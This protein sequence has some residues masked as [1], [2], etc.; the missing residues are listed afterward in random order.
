MNTFSRLSS[1]AIL[2][3]SAGIVSAQTVSSFAG[4]ENSVDP[5]SNFSN[6]TADVADAYFYEP[7][8]ITWDIN[9]VMY[10]TDRN[11]VRIIK[12][13]KVYN[14]SGNLG[15]GNSSHGYNDGTGVIGAMYHPRSIVDKGNGE[16]FIVDSENHAIRKLAKFVNAGN[17][18]SL[19]TVAGA[20]ASGGQ[21][22]SGH[23]DG[24]G[25]NSRFD[26]PKGIIG[27]G[28]GN[29][30]ICDDLNFVIR[31]MTSSGVVSTIAGQAGTEGRAD[32]SSGAA[33]TFGGPHGIAMYDANNV[34]ITDNWNSSI[35]KVNVKTGATTTLC[36]KF[37]ENWHK[38][39]SLIEARFA[40]PKGIAVVDGLIYVADNSCI[41][42]IDE[43]NGTVSTF[44]G[45]GSA[46]GNS[47]GVGPDARFGRL[48][49]LAF[50]GNNTIY[51]TDVFFNVIKKVTIDNLAPEADFTA[52]K[53]NLQVNEETTISDASAGKPAT[54]RKWTVEDISGSASN[55]TLVSGDL[56]ASKDITVKFKA[57]GFYTVSLEVTNE[58]GTD[59]EEKNSYMNV[60]TTGSVE[61]INE[62][63][64]LQLYPNPN[65]GDILNIRLKEGSFKNASVEVFNVLGEKVAEAHNLNGFHNNVKLPKL[66]Q[67]AYIVVISQEGL[68][69]A[70]RLI[71]Q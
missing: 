6:S 60:S 70:K 65:D 28:S 26:T 42:V 14:R 47:N 34:I 52:T 18:Q 55:V 30:Y 46:A 49:G 63:G 61:A 71:V 12:D 11:K 32:G 21:G 64:G 44:A 59:T 36:G 41:R 8:G 4:K 1:L 10:V 7:E 15:D 22:T 2:L 50:D 66:N 29:F 5:W 23:K 35:R 45:S 20:K 57:T 37:G 27:D 19:T 58:Y 31:K 13:G 54:Q 69:G 9:G 51:V 3:L 33:S 16:M 43:K 25:T 24:S 17:G 62:L 68:K 48:A 67:G 53:T 39:G 40:N 56:N 38:D